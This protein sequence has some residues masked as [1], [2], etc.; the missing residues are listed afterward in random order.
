MNIFQRVCGR[1]NNCEIIAVFYV[2]CNH[3]FYA[4]IVLRMFLH[5][6]D[7]RATNAYKRYCG[8]RA[9][10]QANQQSGCSGFRNRRPKALAAVMEVLYVWCTAAQ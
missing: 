3:G 9:Y 6:V 5:F 2:T 1:L 7:E 10:S 4:C 8:L